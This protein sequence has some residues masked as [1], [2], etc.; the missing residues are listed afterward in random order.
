MLIIIQ[1]RITS[2]RLPGKVLMSLAGKPMLYWLV[3][4]LGFT[5]N[6]H[7]I[8]IATSKNKTDNPI[9]EFCREFKI[10]CY[11]GNLDNVLERFINAC[12]Y[13]KEEQCIRICGDSPLFDPSLV[14]KVIDI[15]KKSKFDLITNIAKRTYPKGQSIEL[16]NLNAL[17]ILS[18]EKLTDHEK[19][20]VTTGIYTREKKFNIYNF[21]EASGDFS[22]IQLSVDTYKDFINAERLINLERRNHTKNSLFTWNE[23]VK[24]L[25][26]YSKRD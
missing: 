8:I 11:R 6:R 22:N 14:D 19:E 16:I 3:Y 4:R 18:A 13:Y 12:S 25:Q 17:K 2:K 21:E 7:Q 20:H 5:I 24:H 23:Y 1:A 15:N 9:F 10:D 26:D